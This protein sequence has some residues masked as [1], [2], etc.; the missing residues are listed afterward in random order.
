[1]VRAALHK[2]VPG[3]KIGFSIIENRC[4]RTLQHDRVI[5]RPGLVHSRL[6][7]TRFMVRVRKERPERCCG[8]LPAYLRIGMARRNIDNPKHRASR[9]RQDTLMFEAGVRRI[10]YGWPAD[11]APVI[12]AAIARPLRNLQ[13]RWRLAILQDEGSSGLVICGYDAPLRRQIIDRH[14]SLPICRHIFLSKRNYVKGRSIFD[15]SFW[16]E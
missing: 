14:A 12:A 4:Y 7:V 11:R 9:R 16:K 10:Y 6:T 8:L 3:A 2:N 5:D 1:M 15:F 13:A